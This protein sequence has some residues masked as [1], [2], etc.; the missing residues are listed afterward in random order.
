MN[1]ILDGSDVNCIRHIRMSKHVFY[2]LCN[3]LR[4]NNLLLSTKAC[5]FKNK[6]LIFLEIVGFN[7]QFRKVGSHFYRS[8]K[9]ILRCFH[10]ILQVILKLYPFLIR[11]PDGTIQLEIR[12]NY[13]YY[14]WFAVT[15]ILK[16]QN[17]NHFMKSST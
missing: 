5:I 15:D 14:P 12:K 17:L 3:A 2:E 10:M 8:I 11:P 9:S 7:E 13:R 16:F 4:R 6:V 1:S